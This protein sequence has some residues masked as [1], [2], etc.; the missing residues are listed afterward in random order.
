MITFGKMKTIRFYVNLYRNYLLS[1]ANLGVDLHGK[2]FP[3]GR[4]FVCNLGY[5]LDRICIFSNHEAKK[6]VLELQ[7]EKRD[8]LPRMKNSKENSEKMLTII[9]NFSIEYFLK[10]PTPNLEARL[11]PSIAQLPNNQDS[12]FY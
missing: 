2:N 1:F 7:E 6:R 4:Y 8:H 10:C 11:N 12:F 5:Y 9:S 3:L